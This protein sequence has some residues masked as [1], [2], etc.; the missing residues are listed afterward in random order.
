MAQNF[1]LGTYH[2][3]GLAAVIVHPEQRE[4]FALEA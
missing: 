1:C 4:V 2:H 3:A